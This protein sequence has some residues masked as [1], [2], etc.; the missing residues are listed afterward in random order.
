MEIH[1]ERFVNHHVHKRSKKASPMHKGLDFS[2][3]PPNVHNFTLE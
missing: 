2:D 3:L 1:L